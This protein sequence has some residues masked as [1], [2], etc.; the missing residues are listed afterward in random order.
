MWEWKGWKSIIKSHDKSHVFWRQVKLCI[1][2]PVCLTALFK[3]TLTKS[4]IQN[5]FPDKGLDSKIQDAVNLQQTNLRS[6]SSIWVNHENLSFDQSSLLAYKGRQN[7]KT[8][9]FNLFYLSRVLFG[10]NTN[11]VWIT[12]FTYNSKHP[13]ANMLE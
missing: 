8:W 2:H 5:P 10:A 4:Y 3:A 11:S 7:L 9:S 1:R 12:K 6:F 13:I